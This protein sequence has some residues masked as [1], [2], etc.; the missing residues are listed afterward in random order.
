M[1]LLTKIRAWKNKH[2]PDWFWDL[3]VGGLLSIASLI[4]GINVLII[5]FFVTIVNQFYNKLF[6]QKDFALRM[7]IPILSA[8]SF[9]QSRN[10]NAS[11]RNV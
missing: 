8:K 1:K 5:P 6:E 2:F 11:K 9:C 3:L 7:A 4:V 10:R